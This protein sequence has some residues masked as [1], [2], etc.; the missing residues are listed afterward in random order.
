[1]ENETMKRREMEER[2][3]VLVLVRMIAKMIIASSLTHSFTTAS[4]GLPFKSV[5]V[6]IVI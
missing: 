3:T 1:V 6:F 4:S 2:L 5:S